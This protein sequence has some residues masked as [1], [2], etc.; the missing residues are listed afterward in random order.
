MP[1]ANPPGDAV[2]PHPDPA[3]PAKIDTVY[4]CPHCQT[5]YLGDQR[6][7]DCNTW[8]RRLGPGGPCPHCDDL[9]AVED[10]VADNQYSAP[11]KANRQ[12]NGR[13]ANTTTRTVN[14]TN[15]PALPD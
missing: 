9:V 1:A 4:E 14:T 8:C 3:Q 13:S 10:L 2:G 15:T 12:A 6:C 11:P 7:Q 5:R